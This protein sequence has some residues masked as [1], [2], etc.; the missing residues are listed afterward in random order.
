MGPQGLPGQGLPGVRGLKGNKGIA[1]NQGVAGP[2]G[3]IG[4]KGNR[5]ERGNKGEK[6]EPGQPAVFS[7]FETQIDLMA[8]SSPAEG[9]VA[10][11]REENQLYYYKERKWT[12]LL[13]NNAICGDGKVE[14]SVEDCDDGNTEND[15]S[16]VECKKAICGDNHAWKGIEE[17][18]GEDLVNR[19]CETI[20][21]PGAR[22]KLSCTKYCLLDVSSCQA[23]GKQSKVYL[24]ALDGVYSGDLGGVSGADEMC[25]VAAREAGRKEVYRA[26]LASSLQPV[27]WIL[28]MQDY[29]SEIYNIKDEV[30]FTSWNN[31]VVGEDAKFPPDKQL[32]TFSGHPLSTDKDDFS[33]LIWHGSSRDGKSTLQCCKDWLS[34]QQSVYGRASNTVQ[35][36]L[37]QQKR[38]QCSKTSNV[39]CISVHSGSE[40]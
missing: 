32:Y 20:Y 35:H 8:L 36:R 11:T 21:G 12:R 4:P 34:S 22:G 29:S 7:L 17:C 28:P 27:L 37:L 15:D 10:Y 5:G 1:G 3:P 18:D 14:E 25:R 23:S 2:V 39:L 30:L 40:Q 9:S 19:T 16:C 6:G 13:L 24:V 38:R 33:K 31:S 26:L